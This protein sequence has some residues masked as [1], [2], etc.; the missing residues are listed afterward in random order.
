[1]PYEQVMSAK[2]VDGRSDIYA[3]GATLYHLVCG[4]VPF[5]GQ[6]P[7]E[8]TEKK[9][10]GAFPPASSFHPDIPPVLD[11][12][13]E[14]MLALAPA[15]RY[16]T[17]SELIVDLERAGLAA[18]VPSFIQPEAALRDPVVRARLQAP[19]QP[20]QADMRT[21]SSRAL[22]QRRADIWHLRYRNRNGNWSTAK[23]STQHLQERLREGRVPE[24]S[25]VSRDGNDFHAPVDYPELRTVL[26]EREEQ[27]D[28]AA[29]PTPEEAVKS[30]APVGWWSRKRRW[31]VAA[32][33]GVGFV[34]A[35]TG[36]YLI[37]LR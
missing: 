25:E 6:T 17:V 15:A 13:L 14:K 23:I 19:V 26:A 1:M 2:Q 33:L 29:A 35:S 4:E 11:R 30:S 24:G 12:I 31:L 36:A 27:K 5:P 10:E 34:A 22:S 18:A 37:W 32:G 9:A 28:K 20:T 8:V 3:L 21:P 7:L 16:Q